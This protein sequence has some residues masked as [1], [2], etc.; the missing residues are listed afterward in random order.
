MV[1]RQNNK[2]AKFIGGMAE[3]VAKI[4]WPEI[5]LVPS[6]S[7]ED[8]SGIDAYIGTIAIQIK[9]DGTIAKSEKIFHEIY[10]KTGEWSS[11]GESN[12]Q[13]RWSPSKA[14]VYIFVTRGFAVRVELNDLVRVEAHG[15]RLRELIQINE[16]AIGFLIP[17]IQLRGLESTGVEILEHNLWST[18]T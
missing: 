12:A 8:F 9:G 16:T 14:D 3:K 17:L 1:T 5:E 15:G 11:F 7:E 10:K 18:S 4:L 2:D 13:W 6:G